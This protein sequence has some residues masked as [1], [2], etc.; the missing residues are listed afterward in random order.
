MLRFYYARALNCFVAG[1]KKYLPPPYFLFLSIFIAILC[2]RTLTNVKTNQTPQVNTNTV[3]KWCLLLTE[4]KKSSLHVPL[5]HSEM[6]QWDFK[7][8][9]C[10]GISLLQYYCIVTLDELLTPNQWRYHIRF[11][12]FKNKFTEWKDTALY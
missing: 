9:S 12:M 8:R 7:S 11:Y 5:W 3:S 2:F 4:K 6:T 1:V 10:T